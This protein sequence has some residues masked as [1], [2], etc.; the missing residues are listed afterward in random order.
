[1]VQENANSNKETALLL[2]FE[3][4]GITD[5]PLVG[6]KNASLGEMIKQLTPKGVS[7]PGGFATTANAYRRFIEAGGLEKKLRE[8]FADLDVEDVNNL[9]EKGKEARSLLLHTPFPQDLQDEITKAYKEMCK[10]YGADTDVAVRSSATAEDLP[11]A[12]FA[13]QQETYLN[14]HGL[15]S[16]LESC[17]KCFASI[18]TDRAISYRT[19]KGFDHFEVALSVGVQKMVRSDLASSG[20]MFSIDTETGFKNAAFITAAYGLGENVVQGAVNPDEYLVFKPTLKQGY[21]PILDKRLG[22]KEIKMVYDIGGGKLTKN[23]SVPVEERGKFAITDEE[24]LKL[25]EW[26]CIIEDHYSSV[27]GKDS[28]MDIEWAKDGITGELFIVQARPETVQSQKTGNVLRN[29]QLKGHSAVLSTGRSVGEMIGQGKARVIL[30][31]SKIDLFQPG[32]V[33]ITRRTDPDWEP[34]MKKA[35]AIVTDQGGRT[36]H[37][38]II[39]REMG[40]PAIVG[41][42]DATQVV[43]TGQEVTVC[44]SEGDEGK[45]Y[46]GLLPFNV[47]E[48]PLENLPRTRTKILMNVGNPEEAFSFA[49]IPCDGVGLARL[50]F[51][52]ANHIKCHPLALLKF[53][54][55]E[56]ES[57]KKE[58]A[59]LTA[60]YADKPDFFTDKLAHGIGII[61]AAFYPNP[62]VVRMSD[63]KSNEY[64]NLLG[65][66]QFEPKEEN[67][68]IGWRGASR[69]YDPKYREAFGLECK[70]LKRVRDEMGLTNV[71]PMIPF[72]RTPEEGRKVLSEMAKHGLERGK[73][74]L[75]V[76]VMC[77]LP[78]NVIL[79]DEFAQVFDGF[80]IGSN[81]L[82]Q[83]TLGLDRDSALVAHIFDERNE[84]VK[85]M[86]QVAIASAKKHGRKIGICGQAPSDYPE[87]ARFLVELGIDSIS[88]NP[89]SVLKTILDIALVEESS[90]TLKTIMD[91]AKAQ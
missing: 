68:M 54:E 12:S 76:Y 79:A 1:M 75:Q 19:I 30:D 80:S 70:A 45:I 4:V 42:G 62:V 69:Y 26:A 11:D 66:K 74:S 29:Y 17:H 48:T 53:N 28:P 56:D 25:A 61:A 58:I 23:V 6:G 7:V 89:D 88:L 77:E 15:K 85:R 10:R 82:T 38:A 90:S 8:L 91:V 86:V 35:S 49:S 33:L 65:G 2:W 32:E 37:A 39:A 22:T 20:V 57:V 5:I 34:I 43:K 87:F 40:I 84:A 51:I 67:P 50:E 78:S 16:V 24:T 47:Q 52:I 46:E 21:K 14:V 18:F 44:C 27:R 31:V 3:E 9:R 64:A 73:N 63:F 36:C 59:D 81:D 55:L 13:G 83:L 72:C 60:L 71:I 41:C